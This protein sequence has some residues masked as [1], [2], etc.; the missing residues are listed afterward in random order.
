MER[1][2]EPLS[3]LIVTVDNTTADVARAIHS[4][5]DADLVRLKA[6]AQLWA[7]GLSRGLSW[8]DVLHE[9]I[10]RVLDGSRK[11]P[12][13]IPIL[14]FL[15]GVMRS[16]CEDQR[17]RERLEHEVLA[18]DVD[19]ADLCA[20]GDAAGSTADPERAVSAAQSL[21][22]VNRLFV[23]DPDALKIIA[24]LSDGLTAAEICRV[25]GMSEREYDTT[26]KRMRRA[27]LRC[28]LDWSAS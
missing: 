11:W 8:S 21:A 16:I 26:R 13:G 9:A 3:G 18:R 19:S 27:L 25:Y 12:R 14:A 7:R 17:R 6:L 5:S 28:G 15:S 2:T 20:V 22:A 1:C 23:A 4:L 24:G 10:A